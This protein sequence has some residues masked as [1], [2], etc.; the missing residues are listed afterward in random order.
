MREL[1]SCL[2]DLS[3]GMLRAIAEARGI[4]LTAN[5]QIASCRLSFTG[6]VAVFDD[7]TYDPPIPVELQSFD[8]E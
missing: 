5:G 6:T 2:V 7:L 1:R 4:E 3:P 8:V